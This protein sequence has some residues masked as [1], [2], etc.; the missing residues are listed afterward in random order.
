MSQLFIIK[1]CLTKYNYMISAQFSNTL[2]AV[3]SSAHCTTQTNKEKQTTLCQFP[4]NKFYQ[5]GKVQTSKVNLSFAT[6]ISAQK[7]CVFLWTRQLPMMKWHK[8]V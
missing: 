8:N 2:G 4:G 5:F 1:D 7:R 6:L 3:I